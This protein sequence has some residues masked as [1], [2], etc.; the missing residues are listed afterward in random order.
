MSLT[1]R[2]Y[3]TLALS[4]LGTIKRGLSH[5]LVKQGVRVVG[6]V[7]ARAAE[8]DIVRQLFTVQKEVLSG[9]VR[10][11][12]KCRLGVT[13]VM[14]ALK[15]VVVVLQAHYQKGEIVPAGLSAISL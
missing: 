14:V 10:E 5:C 2:A 6:M 4:E 13:P 9:V 12:V 15:I 7:V 8:T 1:A 3:T 11:H